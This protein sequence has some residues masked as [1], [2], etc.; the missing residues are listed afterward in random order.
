M[1]ECVVGCGFCKCWFIELMS[2]FLMQEK[3]INIYLNQQFFKSLFY[4]IFVRIKK[5][6]F[7]LFVVLKQDMV[8]NMCRNESQIFINMEILKDIFLIY[9][10]SIH[11][12]G[13]EKNFFQCSI[14]LVDAW[15]LISIW[16][17]IS[18]Y[19]KNKWILPWNLR[20]HLKVLKLDSFILRY[21]LS[22]CKF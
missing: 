8:E 7:S 3:W 11:L 9:V 17:F 16:L 20:K 15:I 4:R 14:K 22:K 6:C 2:L 21:Y 12:K 5:M 1:G 10:F 19:S 18:I 13:W